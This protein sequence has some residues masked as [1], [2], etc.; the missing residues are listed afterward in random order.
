MTELD[1]IKKMSGTGDCC[2]TLT[3]DGALGVYF[4]GDDM[5]DPDIV[6]S[7]I[8]KELIYTCLVVQNGISFDLT[9]EGKKSIYYDRIGNL[10]TYGRSR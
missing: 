1:V 4:L 8:D 6:E 10:K 9:E 3:Y 5:I 7:L 2:S